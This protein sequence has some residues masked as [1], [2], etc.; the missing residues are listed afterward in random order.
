LLVLI[1]III[2]AGLT[3][4]WAMPAPRYPP[5]PHDERDRGSRPAAAVVGRRLNLKGR[6]PQA[7]RRWERQ[8]LGPRGKW[9]AD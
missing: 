5:P 8:R 7:P 4:A 2:V 6:E 1:A 3:F 9:V